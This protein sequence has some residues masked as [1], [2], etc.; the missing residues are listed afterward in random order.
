[1]SLKTLALTTLA[2]C[3]ALP[4]T[5]SAQERAFRLGLITPPVH[6]WNEEARA[7]GETLSEM[8]DGR[9]SVT[10]FP[11][12]QLG[13]ESA[14]LQQLQTGA[15]DM[16][17]LTTAEVTTRVPDMS[18]LHAPFLVDDIA[19]AAKVLRSEEAREILDRLPRATGTVGLCYAMTGMRQLMTKEPVE[20]AEDLAG[21]RFRITPAPPI[22][23]FFEMLG[24]A[25][26]P[27]PL[28]QVYDGLANGQI[29]AIDMDHESIINFGYHDHVTHMLETNHHLFGMVALVS[30][31]VWAQL[32]DEDKAL[33]Q[34][35]SQQHCDRTIDRF[36]AKEADKLETLKSVEGLTITEDVDP[37]FFGDVVERWDAVWAEQ[38]P[39]V[40]RL[41]ELVATF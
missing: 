20:S 6:V 26:A 23:S 40:Q 30:G 25:P 36:V 14:M 9:L 34:D 10:T 7:L 37:A 19:D 31:R 39:Y 35:A 29:D 22:R 4:A 24:A 28:T 38:T 11:S 41:R 27:M 21:M 33:L 12:G 15:L 18:A 17:W 16:A 1:M 2:A 8:S 32:S 5:L 3:A 13:S